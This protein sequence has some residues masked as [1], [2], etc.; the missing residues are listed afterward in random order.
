MSLAAPLAVRGLQKSFAELTA[1]ADI[2]LSLESG[3]ILALLGAS[4]C[5]KTTLLR[6]IAGL[7]QP[8]AGSIEIAGVQVASSTVHLPSEKRGIGMVFQDYAL[9]PHMTVAENVAFPLQMRKVSKRQQLEQVNWALDLVGLLPFAERRP[10][11]LS[12]GQQQRVA[13]ARAIV[14]KPKLLL[15]DEPLSNLDKGL[16]ESLAMDIRRLVKDLGLAA[17]FV[18]HDQHEAY[19]LADRI[20]LLQSGHLSQLSSAAK[21]YQRPANA[22]IARF[23]DAGSLIAGQFSDKGFQPANEQTFWPVYVQGNYQGIGTLLVPRS[24]LRL[25]ASPTALPAQVAQ[26][27]FQ[28]EHYSLHL[29]VDHQSLVLNCQ[30]A[31]VVNAQVSVHLDAERCRA[32]GAEQQ[33]LHLQNKVKTSSS[34]DLVIG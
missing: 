6:C 18:T 34:A 27:V 26:V 28:G 30:Q 2:N 9:W 21:L 4:G 29:L 8:D 3:E 22:E 1:L 32:W 24:A 10:E 19:A 20:A 23:L 25:G 33:V 14:G 11:T 5:G 15:M 13:L 7:L 31:Q 12:G 17:V 16:R